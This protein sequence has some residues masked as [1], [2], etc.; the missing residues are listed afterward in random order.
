MK[1]DLREHG[2]RPSHLHAGPPAWPIKSHGS[3]AVD[4][5]APVAQQEPPGGALSDRLDGVRGCRALPPVHLRHAGGRSNIGKCSV[6]CNARIERP[7]VDGK[8]FTKGL[9][10]DFGQTFVCTNQGAARH[11]TLVADDTRLCC[12]DLKTTT[13]DAMPDDRK[14]RSMGAPADTSLSPGISFTG[15]LALRTSPLMLS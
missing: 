2:E 9:Y 11:E 4:C 12:P 15:T 3:V 7:G 8:G 14:T 5:I 6:F 1:H 10:H 13:T